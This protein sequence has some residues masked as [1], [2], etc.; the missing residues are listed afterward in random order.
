MIAFAYCAYQKAD[1]SG[2][3]PISDFI[4]RPTRPAP[5]SG[6][7]G[8]HDVYM[9]ADATIALLALAVVSGISIQLSKLPRRTKRLVF[10][11]EAAV[12]TLI[13]VFGTLWYVSL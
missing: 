5:G 6:E 10:G 2:V 12:L 11:A 13:I 1:S 9:A 4:G 7:Y 3:S 8:Y